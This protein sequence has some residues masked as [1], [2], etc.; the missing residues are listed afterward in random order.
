MKRKI[1]DEELERRALASRADRILRD[2]EVE[3]RSG[4]SRTT[5][6]RLVKAAKFPKPV[7]ITDHAIGWRESEIDV[8]LASRVAVSAKQS[9]AA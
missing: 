6:W 4:L 8:W 3:S 5:P 7:K 1:S 9:D 2:A